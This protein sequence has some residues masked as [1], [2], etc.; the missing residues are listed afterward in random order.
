MTFRSI[1]L[2]RYRHGF[3]Q[4]RYPFQLFLKSLANFDD[5]MIDETQRRAKNP[6]AGGH[7]G[8]SQVVIL[9]A[10]DTGHHRPVSDDIVSLGVETAMRIKAGFHMGREIGM[11]EVE[12]LVNNT[13]GDVG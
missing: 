3:F 10:N 13:D 7:P 4:K 2:K 9:R 8:H 5:W 12:A 6:A 11:K 1:C